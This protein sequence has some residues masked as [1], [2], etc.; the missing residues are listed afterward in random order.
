MQLRVPPDQSMPQSK[1][2]PLTADAGSG[3]Y[4]PNATPVQPLQ[5]IAEVQPGGD[6]PEIIS[7]QVGG[8]LV[9]LPDFGGMAK[10]KVLEKCTELGIRLQ[11]NGS[12]VA[13]YQWPLPGSEI[14]PGSVCSVTFAKGRVKEV[15]PTAAAGTGTR[16]PATPLDA[17]RFLRPQEPAPAGKTSGSGLQKLSQNLGP[18]AIH[19]A[20]FV[21]HV[22][23]GFS[24]DAW[25]HLSTYHASELKLRPTWF[26]RFC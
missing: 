16:R 23:R 14:Q 4:L 25:F 24:P 12:G 7:V 15:L 8:E 22:G 13:V 11:A 3:D 26:S 5:S 10:R 21:F 19:C 2:S 1:A 17:A 20:A 9:V 6:P 18:S